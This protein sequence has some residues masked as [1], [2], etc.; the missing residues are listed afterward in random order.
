M[1]LQVCAD[2]AQAS[3]VT[4]PVP[5]LLEA[6]ISGKPRVDQNVAT[7]GQACDAHAV[8]M[9]LNFIESWDMRLALSTEWDLHGGQAPSTQEAKELA[10]ASWNNLGA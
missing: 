9:L 1:S 8:G 4:L 5:R 3:P 6:G 2:S 7:G 10:A